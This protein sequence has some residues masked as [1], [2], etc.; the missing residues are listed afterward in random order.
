VYTVAPNSRPISR[1]QITSPE[2]AAK[3]DSAIAM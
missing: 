2:S 1:V 3:P